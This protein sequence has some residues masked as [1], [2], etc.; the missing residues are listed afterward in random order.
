M[1]ALSIPTSRALSLIHLPDVSVSRERVE[2]GAVVCRIAPSWL[3][4]GS[5][6]IH[7]SRDDW[8]NLAKLVNYVGKEVLGVEGEGKMARGVVMGVA[9]RTAKMIAGWQAYG[10]M[11]G[12]SSLRCSDDSVS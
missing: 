4:L 11:H 1:A 10:F 8:R 6:E 5:F 12:V 3:R 9:K 7:R 2:T